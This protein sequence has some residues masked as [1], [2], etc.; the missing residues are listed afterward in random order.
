MEIGGVYVI[1]D[2]GES[3]DRA[4]TF[5]VKREAIMPFNY[6]LHSIW[7][8]GRSYHIWPLSFG[9]Q[10]YR[11]GSIAYQFDFGFCDGILVMRTDTTVRQCLTTS[12]AITLKIVVIES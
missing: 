6:G 11:Y 12:Y 8:K 1:L 2:A 5:E 7:P 9:M 4:L 3:L 10:Q